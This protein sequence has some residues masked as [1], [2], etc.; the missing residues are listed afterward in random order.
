A[1]TVTVPWTWTVVLALRKPAPGMVTAA[2]P[3]AS[4]PWT[5]MGSGSPSITSG[6]NSTTSDTGFGVLGG[7]G[8]RKTTL[9]R[10]TA[11]RRIAAPTAC[12]SRPLSS[13][14]WGSRVSVNS[15]SRVLRGTVPVTGTAA[16]TMG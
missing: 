8:S 12:H 13:D 10:Y 7:G 1:V 14:V 9:A 16:V 5:R 15:S 11:E 3:C 2:R 4:V 6:V